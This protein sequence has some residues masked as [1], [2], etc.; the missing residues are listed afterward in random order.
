MDPALGA[1]ARRSGGLGLSCSLLALGRTA[2]LHASVWKA[3]SQKRWRDHLEREEIGCF[4]L[5]IGEEG[6]ISFTYIFSLSIISV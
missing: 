2:P 6:Y 3:W 5:Q 4:I 1:G